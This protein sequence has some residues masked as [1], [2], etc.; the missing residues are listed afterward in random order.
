M[1]D[2]KGQLVFLDFDTFTEPGEIEYSPQQR[3]EILKNI[4]ADYELFDFSFTLNEPKEGDFSTL[5]FNAGPI[6]GL[7]EKIDFRNL[8]KNDTAT[9]NVNDL[10]DPPGGVTVVGL[11]SF[12]GAHELGHLQGLRHGD[13]FAPIGSGLPSTGI[14]ANDF[15]L[16]PYPGPANADETTGRLMAT[17]ASVG[18]E[19]AEA[20]EDA[21]FS[22]RSA[23]KLAFNED[24][25]VINEREENNSIATAQPIEF[26]SLEVPNPLLSGDNAGKDF[27]VEALVVRGSLETPGDEDWYSFE[28]EAG[29]LF[30][31]EVLSD[32]LSFSVDPTAID[33]FSDSKEGKSPED[34]IAD[35]FNPKGETVPHKSVLD[36]FTS[37][38][39]S[40]EAL[41][42]SE[43]G[44]PHFVDPIDP[45]ISIFDSSGNLVPYFSDVAFN[46]DEFESIFGLTALQNSWEIS[47]VFGT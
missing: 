25:T 4:A 26:H 30:Q 28:G 42:S 45:Q 7:A 36:P 19:L 39:T 27:S 24:G 32:V 43:G 3:K 21:F 23:V 13:S 2:S 14:P 15:Y 16:P 6:G 31:F 12:I 37:Q 18:Q 20:N 38:P 33:A 9:I 17:P 8:D 5:F 41:A 46:D 44:P 40:L 47:R 29:D 35:S 11:S 1:T 22:E 10:V 34:A